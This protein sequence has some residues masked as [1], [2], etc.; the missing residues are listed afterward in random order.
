[1]NVFLPVQEVELESPALH[2]GDH[3]TTERPVVQMQRNVASKLVTLVPS[4][5]STGLPTNAKTNLNA[6]CGV[7]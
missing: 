6:H 3:P 7:A 1:M 4:L 5:L 2:M